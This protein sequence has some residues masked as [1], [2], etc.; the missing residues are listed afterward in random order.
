V[1]S[2][3]LP[4]WSRRLLGLDPVRVPPHVF[5]VSEG[6]LRYLSLAEGGE[7]YCEESATVELSEDLF[8]AGPL[9]GRLRDVES[10]TREV[11]VLLGKLNRRPME[12]SLVVPDNWMRLTFVEV[13]EWP[14]RAADQMEV[15]R[16]KLSRIVP[17]RV[18]ELR[19]AAQRVPAIAGG[20]EN[21]FM[22]AFGVESALAQLEEVF[23]ARGVHIGDLS[24]SSLSL[25]QALQERLGSAPLAAAVSLDEDRY[26][27][28]VTRHGE[29]VMYRSKAHRASESL[30]PVE[31][32]LRLT[33]TFLRERLEPGIVS[34]L[35]L[36][37][38]ED[39]EAPWQALAESVFEVPVASL[40]RDWPSIPGLS[41]ITTHTAAPL[42][43]AA[44][45]EVA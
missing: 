28:V 23:E 5:S 37:A 3:K 41:D 18:A 16:F 26:S 32:E 30:D 10:F 6:V 27:L 19:I 1:K 43:G 42:L 2:T 7:F 12:A 24:N 36:S 11:D 39:R 21:R 34:E 8:Q 15:L 31:R 33:K 13:D 38:P 40:S 45:R 20:S 9:G 14:R 35:V 29:P 17:F 44:L 22:V 25:L 4:L